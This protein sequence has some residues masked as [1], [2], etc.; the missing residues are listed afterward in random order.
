MQIDD[1]EKLEQN[2]QEEPIPFNSKVAVIGFF[3]GLFWSLL[4]YVA[5]V[6]KF[7]ELSPNLVLTPWVFGNWKN[8]VLGNF[9]GIFI[10]AL[11]S[12]GAAYLYSFTLKKINKMWPG[13]LLGL[14]LWALVFYVLNPVFPGL[15]SV[16]ELDRNTIIT[17]ICLYLLYGVFVGYSISFEANELNLLKNREVTNE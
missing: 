1:E 8:G 17:T 9:I 12:I 11:L 13:I 10:I 5:Y 16:A 14:L 3:G 6:F 15:K 7:T 4:G 2:Q